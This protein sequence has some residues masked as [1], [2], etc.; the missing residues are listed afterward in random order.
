MGFHQHQG[1]PV[2]NRMDVVAMFPLELVPELFHG[3]KEAASAKEY[4]LF[5]KER[6]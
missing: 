2:F 1:G 4:A 3:A 6:R 5:R